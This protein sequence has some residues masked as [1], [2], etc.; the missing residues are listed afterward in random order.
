ME[1]VIW[2]FCEEYKVTNIQKD[3]SP[4]CAKHAILELAQGVSVL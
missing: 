4:I 2:F 3:S 1:K